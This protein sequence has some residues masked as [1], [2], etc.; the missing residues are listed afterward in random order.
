MF[1]EC[2]HSRSAG[3]NTLSLGITESTRVCETAVDFLTETLTFRR[4][5]V[6]RAGGTVWL[7]L[8]ETSLV[9]CR[10]VHSI[11]CVCSRQGI[12]MDALRGLWF[13]VGH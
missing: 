8:A 9:E 4:R 1:G 2:V 6:P 10:C 3:R 5:E 13:S 11:L 7:F 12:D